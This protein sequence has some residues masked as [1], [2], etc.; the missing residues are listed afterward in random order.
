MTRIPT[1]NNGTTIV[2][3]GKDHA[4]IS[5]TQVRDKRFALHPTD[6]QGEGYVL[7]YDIW[8]GW[9][10]NKIGATEEDLHDDQKLVDLTNKFISTLK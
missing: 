4:V 1:F 10:V 2:F 6:Y 8:L 5:F 9:S 7:D 3:R